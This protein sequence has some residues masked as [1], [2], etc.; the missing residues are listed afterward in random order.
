MAVQDLAKGYSEAVRKAGLYTVMIDARRR[1][2]SAGILYAK[3]LILTSQHAVEREQEIKVT[4]PSGEKVT[5][6]LAGRDPI[7]DLAVVRVEGQAAEAPATV[8]EAKVGDIA[9]SVT[10]T[11]FDGVNA[12]FGIVG[13]AGKRLPFWKGGV[14]ESYYQLDPARA[15]GFTGSPVVDT[16]GRLMGIH[17]FGVRFGLE[18]V[19]PAGLALDTAARIEAHGSIKRG[20][21][22]IRSQE[23]EIPESLRGLIKGQ[24]AGLLLVGVEEKSPAAAAGLMIGDI[25]VRFDG[26][27]IESHQTLIGLLTDATIGR[28][29]PVELLRGGAL[30]TLS[31]TVAAAS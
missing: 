20:Q 9:L 4:L 1:R 22:G 11:S 18:L 23:V 28:S 13:A 24:Q 14:I 10:R 6:S 3:G 12:A 25:L 16:E 2:P 30:K 31:V 5:G 7:R 17:V 21:L 15:P 8:P 26:T 19:I 27:A 29:L